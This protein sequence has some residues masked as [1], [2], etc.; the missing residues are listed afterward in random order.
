M[1]L[2]GAILPMPVQAAPPPPTPLPT[3]AEQLRQQTPAPVM[4][5]TRAAT[6]TARSVRTTPGHDLAANTI[7]D[8][9][10]MNVRQKSAAFL[11]VYGALFGLQEPDQELVLRAVQTDAQGVTHLHY[12]QQYKGIPVFGSRLTVHVDAQ[13]NLYALDGATVDAAGFSKLKLT[14]TLPAAQ[15]RQIA[16]QAAGAEHP[17][18][19]W[20]AMANQI[21][22]FQEGLARGWQGSPHLAY[23]VAVVGAGGRRFVYVDAHS[24]RVI[25]QIEGVQ[26][27][28]RTVADGNAFNIVWQEGAGDPFPIP[29][30]WNA[31]DNALISAWNDELSGAQ[32][33]YNLLG[34]MTNGAWLSYDGQDAPMLTIHEPVDMG[35]PNAYWDGEAAKFCANVTGDDTV[36]HEWAHAYTEYTAGFIYQWQP[37]ALSESYSDIWGEVVD[38]LNGRGSDAPNPLRTTASCSQYGAGAPANDASMRWLAGEDDPGFGGAIRDMWNP[39]CYGHPGKV[40]DADYVCSALDNG[41]VHT[42]AGIPNHLFALLVDGGQYNGV[43]IS[44]IGLT[45]AAHIQWQAQRFYMT[46]VSDFS[47]HAHALRSACRDLTGQPLYALTTDGAAAWGAIA[48]DTITAAHCAELEKAI[49]AVE[50][51]ARP[52]QCGLETLLDPAAPA[53]CANNG[54]IEPIMQTDWEA[55]LGNWSAGALAVAAPSDF[56]IPNWSIAEN[57]PDGRSGRGVFG[58]DPYG[59]GVCQSTDTSGVVY[60]E[61]PSVTLPF[62][63]DT[64]RLAF[65]HWFATEPDWDGGNLKIR[66]NGGAWQLAPASAFE[67]NGYNA[68][69]LNATGGNTNPLAGE[70]AFSGFNS[71]SYSGSWGQSQIDL[72]DLAAAGDTIQVRFEMGV[73]QCSGVTGWYVDDVLLYACSGERLCGNGVLDSGEMCDDGNLADGDG[74]SAICRLEAQDADLSIVQDFQAAPSASAELWPGQPVTFT[75]SIY[76]AG[77]QAAVNARVALTAPIHFVNLTVQSAS[78]IIT[79]TAGAPNLAWQI[80]D[81]AVGESTELIVA[82]NVVETLNVD[83]AVTSRAS[84]A[85]DNDALLDNN[86][87]TWVHNLRPPRVQF[88]GNAYQLYEGDGEFIVPVV[89]DVANP[90]GA[91]AV[92]YAGHQSG[93]LTIPRGQKS[94]FFSV[95]VV[96]DQIAEA[97]ETWQLTL[98]SGAGAVL[99][100]FDTVQ[101]TILDDDVAQ[102]T[103]TP[104]AQFRATIGIAGVT[105]SCGQTAAIQV[106]IGTDVEICYAFQN[107]GEGTL[108]YHTLIDAQWGQRFHNRHAPLAPSA[109]MQFTVTQLVIQSVE[110]QSTWRAAVDPLEEV[111]HNGQWRWPDAPIQITAPYAI[112][113]SDDTADQD[114][115]LIPD[116]VEGADDPD[117]D[118]IPNYLDIDSNNDGVSDTIEAGDNPQAPRDNNRNGIFDYTEADVKSASQRKIFLPL[119]LKSA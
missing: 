19:R 48:P 103:P 81:L 86:M 6:Q 105:A 108:N 119:I 114:R 24:G 33:I 25:E 52:V 26:N 42:N 111:A 75:L 61:S 83:A 115:D 8:A 36:A 113:I 89:L 87:Q 55:G 28:A 53:L 102:G 51:E 62:G 94:V 71:H 30:N 4:I 2:A 34:S 20:Q 99:G 5:R 44:G 37:G 15:A 29:A 3:L 11:K 90:F 63:A 65:D 39:A 41:G 64:P 46:P 101:L 21:Y 80:G 12:A 18:V 49:T 57:L 38:L 97:D 14:P 69:L 118:G 91:V 54:A 7:V 59:N 76:N 88:N 92:N 47:D 107:N 70:A 78:N 27:I 1:M 43:T 45:P 58:P 117:G 73:D 67:H 116:N 68:V 98:T 109:T 66:V 9:S 110:G 79:Q 100:A 23:A 95:P 96:D 50:L 35:C 60:L 10:S 74:C 31:H 56:E 104:P 106:P 85:A 17:A 112:T 84:V 32:E 40:S 22:L 82:G 16:L 72:S 13:G 93:V 77:P